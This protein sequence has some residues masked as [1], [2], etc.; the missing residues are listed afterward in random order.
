MKLTDPRKALAEMERTLSRR[1]L[2]MNIGKGLGVVAAYDKFGPRL[3]GTTP[4]TDQQNYF[5]SLQIFSAFAQM[6]I[7]VDQDPGWATFEPD[8]TVYGLDV[9]IRQVFNLGRDLAFNGFTQAVVA[10]NELPPV[11]KYGRKFLEM[12]VDA[13]ALYLTNILVGAFENDGVNDILS[14]SAVFMLL[15]CKQTFYQNYPKHIPTPGAEFQQVLGNNPRTGWDQMG[16]RGP[17]GPTEEAALRA[18]AQNAPEIPGVDFRN[19][20]I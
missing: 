19:P 15:G 13:R 7:P 9:F 16:F 10:F 5:Q 17:V 18:R 11:I 20:L 2:L 4:A 1:A 6:V 8:I 3:F 14:F 12:S